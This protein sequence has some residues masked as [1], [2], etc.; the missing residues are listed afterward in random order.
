MSSEKIT[1]LG[2]DLD[3][4]FVH[5][6][7]PFGDH[8]V[9]QQ[10]ELKTIEAEIIAIFDKYPQFKFEKPTYEAKF[11]VGAFRRFFEQ[12]KIDEPDATRIKALMA[13]F[14]AIAK[15][16]FAVPIKVNL[17]G[18]E[19]SAAD[20]PMCRTNIC[21]D[22]I[23]EAIVIP[24]KLVV[25]RNVVGQLTKDQSDKLFSVSGAHALSEFHHTRPKLSS[26]FGV[27]PQAEVDLPRA[28]VLGGFVYWNFVFPP[29]PAWRLKRASDP[30]NVPFNFGG[31]LG[32][33]FGLKNGSY[34]LI[35]G[36]LV[37]FGDVK[38]GLTLTKPGELLWKLK[39]GPYDRVGLHINYPFNRRATEH[40]SAKLDG[41]YAFFIVKDGAMVFKTRAGI[42]YEGEVLLPN[43]KGAVEYGSDW[44]RLIYIKTFLS[45]NLPLEWNVQRAVS[46]A[47][48]LQK[49][50]LDDNELDAIGG[51]PGEDGLVLHMATQQWFIK[52][53]RTCDLTFS[54]L[55][56]VEKELGLKVDVKYG[57]SGYYPGVAEYR[58]VGKTLCFVRTRHDKYI[59]NK[60]IRV[61]DTMTTRTI[62]DVKAEHGLCDCTIC[63]YCK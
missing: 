48:A 9:R 21:V 51:N 10:G 57:N 44:A 30:F 53:N 23:D 41:Q 15:A 13:R 45:N 8:L 32:E 34:E 20:N 46:S 18:V 7:Q 25:S 22:T 52:H 14:T 49:I 37:F 60:I 35:E 38:K 26:P 28:P 61:K 40:V 56:E 36:A 16:K 2:R 5:P 39:P 47:I 6:Q 55:A 42:E 19:L 17:T 27:F 31:G 33:D 43:M 12:G 1:P 54:Q 29:T 50:Y 62:S 58:I 59:G 24:D 11:N 4:A 3:K 63:A